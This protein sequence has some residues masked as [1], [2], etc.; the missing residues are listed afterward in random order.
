MNM[1]TGKTAL[2]LTLLLAGKEIPV[3]ETGSVG[4]GIQFREKQ[5]RA[6]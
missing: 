6:P 4:C 2:A 5:E 1:K 3:K